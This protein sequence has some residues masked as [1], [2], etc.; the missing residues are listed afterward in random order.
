MPSSV[1]CAAPA[2]AT[3]R[4]L[5]ALGLS[6]C[7]H[8]SRTQLRAAFHQ[9]ALRF[10]PDRHTNLVDKAAAEERFKEVKTAYEALSM[11]CRA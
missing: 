9:A 7:T 1:P 4:H 2:A 3:L 8:L 6:D 5:S 11:Q 10:H